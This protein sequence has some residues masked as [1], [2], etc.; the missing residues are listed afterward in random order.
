[1]TSAENIVLEPPNAKDPPTRL[2]LSALTI[3]PPRYKKPSYGPAWVT[4]I[5]M[6]PENCT[7]D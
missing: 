3:V 1:M 5:S 4:F 7:H 2:V 6:Y